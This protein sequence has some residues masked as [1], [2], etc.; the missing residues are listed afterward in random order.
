MKAINS[1]YSNP[2]FSSSDVDVLLSLIQEHGF[3]SLVTVRH[4]SPT[5]SHVPVVC[6]WHDNE[7]TIMGH[8]AANN[9][10]A[11]HGAEALVIVNGPNAYVSPG[12]YPD[13]FQRSRVPTWNYAVAHLHGHLDCFKDIEQ[14][15]AHVAELSRYYEFRA[16]GQWAFNADSPQ[17]IAMLGGIIGFRISVRSY[18]MKLKLSQ[19]HPDANK[20]AVIKRLSNGSEADRGVARL[21]ALVRNE[22]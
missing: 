7:L 3:V 17:E 12:W 15:T 8:L 20:L 16:G 14:L 22:A 11:A 9:P 5:V 18:E 6:S 2:S 21:M 4:G 1:I 13:K 10:Q 19:N